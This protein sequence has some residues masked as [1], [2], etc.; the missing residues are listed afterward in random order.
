MKGNYSFITEFEEIQSDLRREDVFFTNYIQGLEIKM[1]SDHGRGLFATRNLKK[2]ELLIVEKP[3]I[4]AEQ[5]KEQHD[6]EVMK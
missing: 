5:V 3:V 1:T 6:V 4:N 2:G